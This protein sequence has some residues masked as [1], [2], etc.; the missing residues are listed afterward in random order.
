MQAGLRPGDALAAATIVPARAMGR[1][2][3]H[4]RI[5]PGYVADIVI[6]HA[7]PLVDITATTR[8]RT[9]LLRGTTLSR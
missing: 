1:A 7:N 2:Q 8:I 4:G 9:V 3:S 5:A 6:L